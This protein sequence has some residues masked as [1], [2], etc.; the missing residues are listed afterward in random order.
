MQVVSPLAAV[1][2]QRWIVLE[3]PSPYRYTN[4][5]LGELNAALRNYQLDGTF[6]ETDYIQPKVEVALYRLRERP[7]D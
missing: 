7:G 6:P 2:G 3:R 1:P 5:I 4:A